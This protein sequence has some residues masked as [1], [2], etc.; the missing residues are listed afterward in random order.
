MSVDSQ[1]IASQHKKPCRPSRPASR[2]RTSSTSTTTFRTTAS[3]P[4]SPRRPSF[5]KLPR[6]RT[7]SRGRQAT[8]STTSCPSSATQASLQHQLPPRPGWADLASVER[9]SRLQHRRSLV[10]I[11][12]GADTHQ[13]AVFS[14][15]AQCNMSRYYLDSFRFLEADGPASGL[16]AFAI[17][18]GCL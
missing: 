2:R 7:F 6:Q 11:R 8:R 9:H 3:L 15:Q 4:V 16:G 12:F 13:N 18:V 10:I 14:Q 17:S 5:H 1:T